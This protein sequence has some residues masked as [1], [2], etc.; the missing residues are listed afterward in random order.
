MDVELKFL[1]TATIVFTVI[2]CVFWF[3][4]FSGQRIERE[5]LERGY[6]QI[7]TVGTG[8]HWQ[9]YCVKRE[10]NSDVVMRLE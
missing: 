9:V 1:L 8:N 7:K 6:P 5:C 2:A 3:V 4:E 10:N